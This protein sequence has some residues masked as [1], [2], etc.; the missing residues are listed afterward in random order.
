MINRLK[1]IDNHGSME[2]KVI[3]R[4]GILNATASAT[5]GLID[6]FQV[7]KGVGNTDQFEIEIGDKI[8]GW[9]GDQFVAGIVTALPYTDINNLDIAST[10]QPF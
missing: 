6:N 5:P 8:I 7:T 2:V 9:I 10:G 3:V 1:I 4:G